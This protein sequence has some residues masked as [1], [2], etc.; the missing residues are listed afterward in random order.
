MKDTT[1]KV[2]LVGTYGN[3]ITHAL[4]A[5]TS[6]NRELS[7]EKLARV[8]KLLNM[9]GENEHATPFEKSS[10]HFLVTSDIATHIHFLKHRIGVSINT[11]SARYKELKDDKVYIPVDW[12]E[13]ERALHLAFC[14]NAMKEYHQCIERLVVKGVARSRAKESAR[15]KLPYSTQ[16]TYDVMFNFRSLMRSSKSAEYMPNMPSLRRLAM[17]VTSRGRLTGKQ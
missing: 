14:E 16:L 11:E 17:T 15:F 6:T 7:A 13:E 4:S 1:N 9:L 5:W 2:E 10:L 8:D 12:D 3:D